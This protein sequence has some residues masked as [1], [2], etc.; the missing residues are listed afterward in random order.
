MLF[1]T[2]DVDEAVT[3]AD[4]VVVLEQGRIAA[5]ER[6]DLARPRTPDGDFHA[7]RRRLLGH[8]GV[9]QES[10][11]AQ[12]GALLPFPARAVAP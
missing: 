9:D 5:E 3:L 6:I 1:I 11:P 8:L 2:H 4:R 10:R 12:E 7:L